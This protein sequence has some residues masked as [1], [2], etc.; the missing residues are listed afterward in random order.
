[1][2]NEVELVLNRIEK[3]Q[4]DGEG[5]EVPADATSLHFLQAIYRSST[6]P[7]QRR[8]RAAIEALPFEM[9]KL[10]V[11]AW[12]DA[13]DFGQRLELALRRSAKVI[14]DGSS[15]TAQ[16]ILPDRRF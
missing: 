9:P 15:K 11:T 3:Q 10:A 5:L 1:M 4:R 16:P 12:M 7:M 8:L 14:E 6:Q 2:G 13:G